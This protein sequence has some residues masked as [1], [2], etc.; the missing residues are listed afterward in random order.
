MV[1]VRRCGPDASKFSAVSWFGSG[2]DPSALTVT[3]EPQLSRASFFT[4]MPT[5][6]R[7]V[8]AHHNRFQRNQESR[9]RVHVIA[10]R[11]KT[12]GGSA[13][14]GSDWPG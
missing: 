11:A 2:C 12:D 3:G 8:D 14:G 7:I 1:P 5:P 9:T 4:A 10:R 13:L 6:C